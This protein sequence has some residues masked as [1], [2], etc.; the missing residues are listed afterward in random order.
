[1]RATAAS[2]DGVE[3]CYETHGDG[4]PAL[5]LV[6]GWSCDRTYWREQVSHFADRHQVVTIDLAG[7]GESGVDRA[8]WT[9]PS[10]G[11][12]VVAVLEQLG[13]PEAVLVGH[14]M[15]GDVIVEAALQLPDRVT[16]LVWVDVYHTLAETHPTEPPEEFIGP[17]RTDFVAATRD[18]IR[19]T[20]A[21]D[22]DPDLVDWI[23]ADMSAAPPEIA[24]D[25]MRHAL[26]NEAAAIT[27]LR[28]L[29]VPVVAINPDR[30]PTDVDA[31]ARHGVRAVLI[32]G[33][34]HFPM[35]EDAAV[36]NRALDETLAQFQASAR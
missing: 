13:S 33:V 12:D 30:P 27:G 2:A 11:A 24:L 32:P 29:T 5:V 14:S 16:G 9:M 4:A 3:V 6:H 20:L 25:A 10:F 19:R 7:H 1:M 31:L 8:A 35:L 23:V 28:K 17:F 26:T 21:P 18:F 22:S 34:R 36:F 15:G